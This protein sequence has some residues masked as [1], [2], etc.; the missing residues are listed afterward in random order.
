MDSWASHGLTDGTVATIPGP[1]PVTHVANHVVT[2]PVK[3]GFLG[4]SP[5]LMSDAYMPPLPVV[6]LDLFI[7]RD[8]CPRS[9]FVAGT[10]IVFSLITS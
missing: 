4:I 1:S 6:K 10:V 7:V 5:R 2:P 8:A 9:M 3:A